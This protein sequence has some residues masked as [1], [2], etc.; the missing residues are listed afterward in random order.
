MVP[1]L[2]GRW[3]SRNRLVRRQPGLA[4]AARSAT[5]GAFSI[6][7]LAFAVS[8]LILGVTGP[9]AHPVAFVVVAAIAVAISPVAGSWLRKQLPWGGRAAIAVVALHVALA[10]AAGALAGPDG[11]AILAWL[12]LPLVA[13]LAV[14][15]AAVLALV[16]ALVVARVLIGGGGVEVAVGTVSLVWGAAFGVSAARGRR[17]FW[18]RYAGLMGL[19]DALAGAA[20]STIVQAQTAADLRSAALEPLTPIIAALDEPR[21]PRTLTLQAEAVR[22]VVRSLRSVVSDLHATSDTGDGLHAAVTKVCARRCPQ[23][24]ITIALDDDLPPD[25]LD[26]VGPVLRDGLAITTERASTAVSIEIRR[27]GIGVRVTIAATPGRQR[28]AR[29]ASVYARTLRHR[30]GVTD[31][32]AR[33]LPRAG[34][35]L[36]VVVRGVTAPDQRL[37]APAAH[38]RESAEYIATSRAGMAVLFPVLWL[39][40]GHGGGPLYSAML[41]LAS[42][43]WI[44]TSYWVLRRA[45]PERYSLVLAL[46]AAL[47]IGVMLLAPPA[48]QTALFPIYG[49]LPATMGSWSTPPVAAAMTAVLAAMCVLTITTG[50][51]VAYPVPPIVV[52]LTGTFIVGGCDAY[53]RRRLNG[54]FTDLLRERNAVVRQLVMEEARERRRYAA[55]LHDDALQILIVAAQDLDGAADG[56]TAAQQRAVALLQ[57]ARTTITDGLDALSRDDQPPC[58]AN[59]AAALENAALFPDGPEVDLRIDPTLAASPGELLGQI[60]RELYVNAAKHARA[61]AVRIDARPD[62][63]GVLLEVVDDGSGFDPALLLVAVERGHIGLASV[64]ERARAAGGWFTLHSD[65]NGTSARAW[66]PGHAMEVHPDTSPIHQ[67]VT[68]RNQPSDRP[69]KPGRGMTHDARAPT[70]GR[71]A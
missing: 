11:W 40:T 21:S 20:P 25:L 64:H 9:C 28:G 15:P 51:L 44:S 56:E 5:L 68:R 14:G 46:D 32:R 23:A 69:A 35:Q 58:T 24:R 62:R 36:S 7:I 61:S 57:R 10:V 6:A 12:W 42:T 52:G 27:A 18:R 33:D 55:A 45:H 4:S 50:L 65:S 66:L 29:G 59:L 38:V 48:L 37:R 43:A 19:R 47:L 13:S 22:A 63:D 31:V 16:V 26:L 34:R 60:A 3:R 53:A 54:E 17:R 41:A 67:T 2:H 70:P 39:I 1:G 49:L 8:T 30:N 71:I